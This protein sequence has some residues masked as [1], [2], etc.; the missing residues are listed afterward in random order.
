MGCIRVCQT[1]RCRLPN[2]H[3]NI[4]SD[5]VCRLVSIQ[6]LSRNGLADIADAYRLA[7]NSRVPQILHFLNLI[8]YSPELLDKLSNKEY[9]ESG[10]ELEMNLRAL[11]IVAVEELRK[12]VVILLEQ[13]GRIEESEGINAVLLDFWLWNK[14]KEWESEGKKMVECHRTRSIWY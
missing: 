7:P 6:P 4:E 2:H 1:F 9:I 10:S 8:D 11:S 5:Y 14:A 13:Q 3:W 12:E